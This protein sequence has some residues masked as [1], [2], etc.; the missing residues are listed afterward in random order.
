MKRV[1]R[2]GSAWEMQASELVNAVSKNF[3]PKRV[4]VRAAKTAE[5]LK[6]ATGMLSSEDS[7]TVRA[8]AARANYLALDKPD[9]VCNKIALQ[10]CCSPV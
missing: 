1:L 7:T 8:L 10:Q 3:K 5:R 9:P 6:H 2:E 4:G